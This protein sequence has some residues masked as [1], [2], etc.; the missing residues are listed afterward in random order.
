MAIY[1]LRVDK[2][3]RS[4]GQ[5]A[6]ASASYYADEPLIDY[7]TGI[8]HVMPQ[9]PGLIHKDIITPAGTSCPHVADRLSLWNAAEAHEKRSDS[10]T[11]LLWYAA[12][13]RELTDRQ[14]IALAEAFARSL[15]EREGNAIDL[16]VRQTGPGS[17]VAFLLCTTR[18]L[19]AS[20]FGAKI[21]FVLGGK[22]REKRGLP[23]SPRTDLAEIRLHWAN[24]VN[25]ALRN[26]GSTAR[27]DHRSL[28]D[29]GYDLIPQTHLGSAARRRTERGEDIDRKA[30]SI[31]RDVHNTRIIQERPSIIRQLIADAGQTFDRETIEIFVRRYVDDPVLQPELVRLVFDEG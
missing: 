25:V 11:A 7:R 6:V 30:G 12:L 17:L 28:K 27:V 14:S 1:H 19:T 22:D 21:D 18:Q 24:L 8:R 4:K 9:R 13:P 23:K 16:T 2:I 5:S 3:G 26:A 10:N 29:R 31:E 15:S 20:G